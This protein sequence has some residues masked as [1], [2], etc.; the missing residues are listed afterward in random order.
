MMIKKFLLGCVLSLCI[1]TFSPSLVSASDASGNPNFY[2]ALYDVV[3]TDWNILG[4]QGGGVRDFLQKIS[5]GEL[6][7]EGLSD[8]LVNIIVKAVIPI[9]ALVGIILAVI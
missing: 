2:T 4:T 7:A 5:T 8:M 3:S 9:L 1:R 6:G